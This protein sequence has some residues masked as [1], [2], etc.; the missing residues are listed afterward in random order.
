MTAVERID[1]HV[2]VTHGTLSA[3]EREELSLPFTK[4]KAGRITY[5]GAFCGAV[6]ALEE[7]NRAEIS[8]IEVL[9]RWRRRGIASG[10]VRELLGRHGELTGVSLERAVPFWKSLG[11]R[12]RCA[13]GATNPEFTLKKQGK[14]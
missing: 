10:V 13:Y 5:D 7:G 1:A 4:E 8:L 11:A 14:N 3:E 2:S 6:E 9:P 12:F